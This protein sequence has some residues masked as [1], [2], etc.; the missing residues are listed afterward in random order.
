VYR[1]FFRSAWL[2]AVVVLISTRATAQTNATN[3][4]CASAYERGQ[5]LRNERKLTEA[6]SELLRCVSDQCPDVARRDC[7]RWLVELDAS[8]P[9]VVF[10]VFGN[11]GRELDQVRISVD[12]KPLLERN[13]GRAYAIDPGAHRFRFEIPGAPAQEQTV[14]V[15]EGEKNRKLTASF[16]LKHREE[17]PAPE[18]GPPAAFWAFGAIGLAGLS[19]ALVLGVVGVTRENDMRSSCAPMCD[20]DDVDQLVG[21]YIGADVSLGVGVLSLGAAVLFYFLEP[22]QNGD[23]AWRV[24]RLGIRF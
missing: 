8:M 22:S 16:E 1:W 4:E 7:N 24:D 23:S 14:V 13:D 12:Q 9:T 15:R 21:M 17:R 18:E 19:A 20:E 5:K 6:R 11:D 10:E 3:A 2:L